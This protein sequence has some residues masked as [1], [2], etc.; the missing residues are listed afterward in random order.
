MINEDEESTSAMREIPSL[1]RRVARYDEYAAHFTR[2]AE[3]EPV[4]S[5]RD[6]W[7]TAARD[8]RYLARA[9]GGSRHLD[10]EGGV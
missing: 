1:R 9:L 6:K 7:E 10:A 4:A 5:I 8:Y 3:A 2:L